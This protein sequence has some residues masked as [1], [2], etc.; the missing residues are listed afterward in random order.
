LP[1]S[2]RSAP[3]LDAVAD[4]VAGRA[5]YPITSDEM[6]ATIAAFEAPVASANGGGLL[7]VLR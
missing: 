3:T 5:V 6:L 2:I 4:A 7:I 1:R